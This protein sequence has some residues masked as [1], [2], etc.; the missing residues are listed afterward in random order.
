MNSRD[1][2]SNAP[3]DSLL[4]VDGD[5]LAYMVASALEKKSVKIYDEDGVFV[6]EYKN[7]TMFKDDTKNYNP[8][9]RIEDSQSLPKN[10]KN[11]M[12][13]LVKKSISKFLAESNC[14]SV[15]IAMGGPTNFRTDLHLPNAYKG[16]RKDLAKP[17]SLYEVRD[18][19]TKAYPSVISDGEEAD[20]ILSKYQFMSYQNRER[21]IVACTL[22]KD[23]RGTP[24]YLYNP[25][26]SYLTFIEGL[27]YLSRTAKESSSGAKK[28]KFYG[29]GRKWFYA[30]LLTGDKADDYFPC[31]IYKQLNV[32]SIKAPLITDLKAFNYL[33][34]CTTDK[35]CWEVIANVYKGWYKDVKEW[36]DYAG[37]TVKGDWIDILQL[38]VD[39][40]HMRRFDNDRVI[41][42]TV[43]SKFDIIE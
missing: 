25:N 20:D 38:Y 9:F 12:V 6:K 26:E 19:V 29:E 23:A 4:V 40:V 33:K 10:Y 28:Y 21:R 22:D 17:L 34:D 18:Y 1:I 35:E 5:W 7:K 27:G 16:S 14:Q 43:L 30:Q 32:N 37:K 31:D 41:V 36:T 3:E 39:V 2:F 42:K 11:N 15:L 24:G 13:F 8:N